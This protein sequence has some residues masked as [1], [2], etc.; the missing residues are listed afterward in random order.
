MKKHILIAFV[1]AMALSVIVFGI[2]KKNSKASTE[3]PVTA[4]LRDKAK[5]NGSVTVIA[6]PDGM[7]R[8]ND[9]KSLVHDSSDIV[10]GGLVETVSRFRTA[11]ERNIVTDFKIVVQNTL[12]GEILSGEEIIVRGPGGRIQ[13]EDGSSAEVK[14]PPYWKNPEMG[15]TYTFFL[16]KKGNVFMLTGGPQGLFE[17]LN[18]GTAQ[19]QVRPQDELMQRYKD[20]DT[21]S[22]LDEVNQS[23]K[24]DT[25][26]QEGIK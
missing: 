1:I 18:N 12:K 22:F 19:P 15:K 6:N 26:Q 13:F 4:S 10:N 14:M 9:V 20:K 21:L 23:I 16:R 2:V 5:A 11:E 24:E 3:K 8:Y 17:M 7:K 25:K